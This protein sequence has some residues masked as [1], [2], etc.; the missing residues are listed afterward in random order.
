MKRYGIDVPIILVSSLRYLQTT[1]FGVHQELLGHF[2]LRLGF[3][4]VDYE[5]IGCL[6]LK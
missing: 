1:R 2:L 4:V 6:R 3:E 5:G